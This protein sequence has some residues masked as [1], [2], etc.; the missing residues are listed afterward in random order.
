GVRRSPFGAC[1]AAWSRRV[2][3]VRSSNRCDG[4][5]VWVSAACAGGGGGPAG[6]WELGPKAAQQYR[7][8]ITQPKL[9]G[10]AVSASLLG[11]IQ[12]FISRLHHLF[13]RRVPMIALGD[14]DAD[15]DHNCLAALA[16]LFGLGLDAGPEPPPHREPARFQGVAQL[17]EVGQALVLA[18][19]G[20][21]ER[22]FLAAVA[23]RRAAPRRLG[24]PRRDE[25]ED[26]V[27][28]VVTIG[29]VES[30]EVID[31]DHGDAELPRQARQR[32]IE[33]PAAGQLGQAV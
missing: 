30:L 32:F 14:A 12:G 9:R 24:Q 3:G 22:E 15:R 31:V 11:A 18:L 28:G 10:Y 26:V 8:R 21:D 2:S 29:I 20:E 17:L 13:R 19:A 27:S 7:R 6:C 23:I 1:S 4:T 25:P 33:G 5:G 16:R